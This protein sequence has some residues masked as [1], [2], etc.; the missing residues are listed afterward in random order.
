MTPQR[1]LRLGWESVPGVRGVATAR[2]HSSRAATAMPRA[3][4][5]SGGGGER[6]FRRELNGG[7]RSTGG[8]Q[9]CCVPS[10]RV[11]DL[12]CGYAPAV[13]D[14]P[15]PRVDRRLRA[16]HGYPSSPRHTVAAPSTTEGSTSGTNSGERAPPARTARPTL[17]T[18]PEGT[19]REGPTLTTAPGVGAVPV[20]PWLAGRPLIEVAALGA[21]LNAAASSARAP[22]QRALRA[23]GADMAIPIVAG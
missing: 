4:G 12:G 3:E 15:P 23:V 8:R 20:A 19:G 2:F 14:W 9:S 18:G 10:G 11:R 16:R 13:P 1:A 6:S 7:P 17:R 22:V 21:V 5:S